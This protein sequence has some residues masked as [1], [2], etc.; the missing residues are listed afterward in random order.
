M[1]SSTEHGI[2]LVL[3]YVLHCILAKNIW[4]QQYIYKI[5]LISSEAKQQKSKIEV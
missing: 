2:N 4:V 3:I 1:L 5:V